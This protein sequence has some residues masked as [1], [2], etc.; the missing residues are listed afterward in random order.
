MNAEIKAMLLSIGSAD[1]DASVLG[2]N[3]SSTAGPDAGKS[4]FFFKSGKHR[5]RL[6]INKDSP[7]KVKKLDKGVVIKKDGIEIVRGEIETA[8]AHCPKQAYITLC[9]KCI[10]D[11]KFCP[12]PKLK[13]KVKSK[14]DILK[15]VD[16]V[17]KAGELKAISLT[18]GVEKSP[19]YEVD[20]AVGIVRVLKEKYNVPI[21]V[22]VVPTKESSQKLHNAGVSEVKYN[23][24]TMDREI[25][26]KV[27]GDFSLD[28]ILKALKEAVEIFGRNHVYSNFIIGLG[29]TD[30]TVRAGVEELADIGVIPILRA[31]NP[32]PLREGETTTIRPSAERLLKLAKMTRS[33]LDK[34]GLRA[35][36]AQTMCLPC[37]G[38]DLVPHID[39]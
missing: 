37:T 29:E 12:V 24:E 34:Y 17:F 32:H 33:I 14:D 23:V 11:C 22:S 8:L 6:G 3:L 7:L 27:C 28:F 30:E 18:S 1:V 19:E 38:C 13:G 9:E 35:D 15:I 2:T 36:V 5:V 39:L 25:F 10:Y 21:G 26:K 20:R 16:N 31:I 4:S